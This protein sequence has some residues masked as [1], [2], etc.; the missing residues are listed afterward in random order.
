MQKRIA[1]LLIVLT[2][3]FSLSLVGCGEKA[4]T[5]RNGNEVDIETAAITTAQGL[6][7]G[8]Y[9]LI[10]VEELKNRIDLGDIMVI[11]D[12]RPEDEF[13]KG[14]LPNAVNAEIPA[15]EDAD[16]DQLNAFIKLLPEN[17]E[18]TIVIYDG[19]TGEGRSA[20]AAIYA[21][22]ATYTNIWRF[23]GGAAAW[24]DAKHK[25]VKK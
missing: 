13:N 7:L 3:I 23:P 12:V 15:D 21:A 10:G 20:R 17:P 14:R 9:Q 22:D 25:L 1:L 16:A 6:T 8:R 24:V 4:G 11:I 5:A 19:Y 2:C 18:T